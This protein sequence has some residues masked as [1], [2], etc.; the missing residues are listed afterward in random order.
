MSFDPWLFKKIY[1]SNVVKEIILKKMLIKLITL[2]FLHYI[3]LFVVTS[4]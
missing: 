4:K 2:S 3:C 1:I